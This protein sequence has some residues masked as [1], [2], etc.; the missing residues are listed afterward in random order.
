MPGPR[1]LRQ[2]RL[3]PAPPARRHPVHSPSARSQ[4]SSLERVRRI[5]REHQP[6]GE[7]FDP[8]RRGT[9]KGSSR[10]LVVNGMKKMHR[11]RDAR[12]GEIAGTEQ[13]FF[14]IESE[15][16]DRNPYILVNPGDY[17]DDG[18]EGLIAFQFYMGTSAVG[19]TNL[20][21]WSRSWDAAAEVAGEWLSDYA[22]GHITSESEIAQLMK[23]AQQDEPD[24]SEDD[25]H[26]KATADLYYTES[27]YLTSHEMHGHDVTKGDPMYKT[28]V[29]ASQEW[30]AGSPPSVGLAEDE[31]LLREY[32]KMAAESSEWDDS[33]AEVTSEVRSVA[34]EYDAALWVA[35]NDL[36][37]VH[38]TDN[39]ADAADLWNAEAPYLVLM[40]LRGEGV[41]IWDGRWDE[42]YS[43][44]K[45]VEEFLK[46][47]LKRFADGSG[48][49]KLEEAFMEAAYE[50]C[51]D[52]SLD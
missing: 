41:G 48:S 30:A 28:A 21:V 50:S 14:A 13:D 51:G 23:E 20:L 2:N 26:E 17:L 45:P 36:L 11:R 25:A 29:E 46:R 7:K 15:P 27:G 52:G 6:A 19:T 8:E 33:N 43:N 39:G 32:V 3:P 42:F 40:T 22:P 34:A 5:A 10:D 1:S 24:L 12:T 37:H 31:Q 35:L 16:N 38:P 18:G 4:E 49:G 47:K 44:T 9:W